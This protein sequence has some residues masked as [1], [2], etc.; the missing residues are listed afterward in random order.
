MRGW[1]A[2]LLVTQYNVHREQTNKQQQQQQQQQ[3]DI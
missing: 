3:M 2:S 1:M